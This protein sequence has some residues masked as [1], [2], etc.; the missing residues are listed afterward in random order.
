M[1]ATSFHGVSTLPLAVSDYQRTE[2]LTGW[3]TLKRSYLVDVSG[4]LD[5][6]LQTNYT[7]GLAHSKYPQMFIVDRRPEDQ[8]GGIYEI[9]V[10]WKGIIN[11]KGYRRDAKILGESSTGENIEVGLGGDYPAFVK[12]LEI[13]QPVLSV[14]TTY[15]QSGFPDLTAVKKP[16][17]SLP[18]GFPALP[19]PPTQVWSSITDPTY[20]YPAGW[21]LDDRST[22]QLPGTSLYQ[23]TDRHVFRYVTKM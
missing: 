19:T 4:N 18:G 14:E 3:D 6:V 11:S 10:E 2:S 7:V 13:E 23:I 22:T 15:M 21:V 20:V 12:T 9:E 1:T 5:D 16:V 8:G 17:G